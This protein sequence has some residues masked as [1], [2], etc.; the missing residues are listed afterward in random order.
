MRPPHTPHTPSH[1]P[2][3]ARSGSPSEALLRP[4]H[5]THTPSHPPGG[6]P[7]RKSIRGAAAATAPPP[8]TQPATR[9]WSDQEVHQRRCCGHRTPPMHPATHPGVAR[10]ANP[11]EVRPPHIP[12][13]PSH[14]PTRGWP[15]QEVHQRRCCGHRRRAHVG[16][17]EQ[18]EGLEGLG[19]EQ[20]HLG[21]GGEAGGQGG[22]GA[23]SGWGGGQ[24]GKLPDPHPALTLTLTLP[25]PWP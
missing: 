17:Q 9:G 11:S 22:R 7:M 1:P 6:G 3:V 10:S 2:G 15:D 16:V 19:L 4:L 13:T 21:G 20:G 18:G 24:A 8:Y 23:I 25:L 14:P 5:T 12:H